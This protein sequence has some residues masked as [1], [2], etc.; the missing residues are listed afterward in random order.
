MSAFPERFVRCGR[1][2][3]DQRSPTQVSTALGF[4]SDIGTADIAK[5][6]PAI[7]YLR[8]AVRQSGS[9]PVTQIFEF[10]SQTGHPQKL[11][12]GIYASGTSARLNWVPAVEID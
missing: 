11:C 10:R 4:A 3:L 1:L 2:T 6:R 8:E 12:C 9:I 5:W 7:R